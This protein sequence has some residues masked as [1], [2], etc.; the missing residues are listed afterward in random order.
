MAARQND[1]ASIDMRIRAVDNLPEPKLAGVPLPSYI[2]MRHAGIAL[3]MR[4][5]RHRV[6]GE[7]D[8]TAADIGAVLGLGLHLLTSSPTLAG[9]GIGRNILH[10][11]LY[12]L[13]HYADAHDDIRLAEQ[14]SWLG[15]WGSRLT[16]FSD[17][18][19]FLSTMPDSA[20][21]VA[22]DTSLWPSVRIQALNVLTLGQVMRAKHAWSGTDDRWVAEVESLV[23]DDDPQFATAARLALGTLHWFNDMGPLARYRFIRRS[24][25]PVAMLR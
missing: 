1:Y 11:G 25:M 22:R 12:E 24:V 19:A 15:L 6:R 10:P 13:A 23:D 5:N 9:S 14:V 8:E 17:L 3:T 18:L 7:L 4:A 21:R 20:L 2:P 16:D